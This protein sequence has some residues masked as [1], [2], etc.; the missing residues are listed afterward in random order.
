[1]QRCRVADVNT[2]TRLIALRDPADSYHVARCASDLPDA[3]A[4]LEGLPPVVGFALLTGERGEVFRLIFNHVRCG[5]WR[6]LELLNADGVPS[7]RAG[8]AAGWRRWSI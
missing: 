2:A 5:D 1:M 8:A 4:V 3:Q 7:E 6:A